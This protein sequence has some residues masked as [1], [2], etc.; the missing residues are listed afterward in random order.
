M[1][2]APPIGPV[3]EL[4]TDG[5]YVTV[6]PGQDAAVVPE[7]RLVEGRWVRRELA[8]IGGRK[9]FRFEIE[10]NPSQGNDYLA[11][12]HGNFPQEI[13]NAP[14]RVNDDAMR[15]LQAAIARGEVDGTQARILLARMERNAVSPSLR[16]DQM[17]QA[18]AAAAP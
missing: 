14:A 7:R 12:I 18:D 8:E 9:N 16:G 4:Q 17:Q 11:N 10:R 5:N 3:R 13:G 15:Q 2:I 6:V 1:N